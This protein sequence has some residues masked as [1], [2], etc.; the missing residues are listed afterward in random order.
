MIGHTACIP[1]QL[2]NL[3]IHNAED[4]FYIDEYNNWDA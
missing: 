1:V 4:I 2:D 3:T